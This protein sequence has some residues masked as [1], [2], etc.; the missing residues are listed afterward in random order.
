MTGQ[1]RRATGVPEDPSPGVAADDAAAWAA[2]AS[3]DVRATADGPATPTAADAAGADWLG[4]VG[5]SLHR[6][7]LAD[8]VAPFPDRVRLTWAVLLRV[9]AGHAAIAVDGRAV[10]VVIGG[11]VVGWLARDDAAP[12][13]ALLRREG[14]ACCPAVIT[15]AERGDWL[16]A[17]RVDRQ[18]LAGHRPPPGVLPVDGL[19]AT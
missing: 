9:P 12:A 15:R 19:H 5:E 6:D 8:V 18:V 13:A 14:A 2:T 1:P 11:R 3:G 17:L 7:A 10:A 16:V 4:V